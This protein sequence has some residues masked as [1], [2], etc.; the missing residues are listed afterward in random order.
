MDSI[1]QFS[2][3]L[4]FNAVWELAVGLVGPAYNIISRVLSTCYVQQLLSVLY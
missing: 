4:T 1:A 3:C 2:M